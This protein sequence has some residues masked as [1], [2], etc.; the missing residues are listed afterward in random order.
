MSPDER[1]VPLDLVG[2]FSVTL[3]CPSTVSQGL[4]IT[5]LLLLYQ[6]SSGW[7]ALRLPSLTGQLSF[8][9]AN[10]CASLVVSSPAK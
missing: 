7:V 3:K 2:S 4:P 10:V 6:D 8:P 9:M 1:F 5:N